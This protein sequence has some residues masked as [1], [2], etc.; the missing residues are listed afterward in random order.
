MFERSVVIGYG[1]IGQRHVNYLSQI[2]TGVIIIDPKPISNSKLAEIGKSFEYVDYL[3]SLDSLNFKLSAKDIVVVANWGPDHFKTV[4][5]LCA[6]GV[7]NIVLEKPCAD[8][9]YEVEEIY[10][11]ATK[12]QIKIAV[13]QGSFYDYLGKKINDISRELDLG[14]IQA[15]WINGGARC[16]ST[17][18]SH[19][20]NLA[21][22]IFGDNPISISGDGF[23]DH[24]NPRSK[25]LSYIEG[26]FSFTYS[27][28]RR[29]A[30]CLTNK[31]SITGSFEIYWANSLGILDKGKLLIHSNE[32]SST[33][34]ITKHKAASKLIFSKSII[35]LEN[36][37]INLYRS[38]E[39][40]SESQ[41]LSNLR[42]HLN[43]NKSILMALI[44]SET[45]QKVFFNQLVEDEFIKKKFRIS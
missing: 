6:L 7:K 24:I 29:L 33:E 37:F 18:G 35:D 14:E 28:R 41:F 11:I 9:L 1:S 2:S 15:I 23:N 4:I 44:S 38:F 27:K 42:V 13:N 5:D 17:S 31:S 8:S 21:S 40:F 20:V 32:N 36:R 30:I 45:G 34:P 3:P 43:S 26:V 39:N 19:W 16:L 12:N 25:N 10:R 22:E